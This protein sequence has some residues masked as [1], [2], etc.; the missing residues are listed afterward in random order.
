MTKFTR[1]DLGKQAVVGAAASVLSPFAG[2]QTS[3][4]Y[5]MQAALVSQWMPIYPGIWKATL[6]TPE[7]V[8]PVHSRLVQPAEAAMRK[9][10]LVESPP[11][12]A[13]TG[14]V[15][16]RGTTI[17]VPLAAHEELY[18]FG[19]QFFSLHHRG[20]K[21][22]IRVNADPRADTGDSHAPVP[23]YISSLGYGLFV[24]TA[25]YATFYCGNARPKPTEP[26][27]EQPSG[28]VPLY[29][30][31]LG[32]DQSSSVIADIPNA[33]GVDVYLFAGPTSLD[34]VRR[35]NLFSGGGTLPPEW[36]LGFWYRTESNATDAEVIATG[37]EFRDRNIPCDVIGL[38]AG[39]H[40]H[41]YSCTF[42]WN[43]ARFPNPQPFVRDLR[44][45]NYH[46][47]LWEHAF[48]HPSSP[49]FEPM[50]G[51]AGDKGVWGGL[52]PDF[53]NPQARKVFGN[54]HGEHLIDLGISG[55]KLDECD[56]SDYTGSWSFGEISQFPSGIDG[57]QMHCLFGL[58]YQK[59]LWDEYQ[60]R[61]LPTYN[62]VRSSGALAAPYPFVLYSDL[63]DHRQF[64]RALVN[65]SF[66][67][68][69]WCP[70]VRDAKSEEDLIRRLQSVM[71][72]PL[73]MING[74]Y[75]KNPPWKQLERRKN[76]AGNLTPNWEQLEERCREIIGWRMQ[77]LPYLQA[78][79]SRY[80]ADGTPPVRALA[81]DW[82]NESSV[83]STDDAWM[84]GDRM[85]VAPLFAGEPERKLTLPPGNWYDFW[86]GQK[87]TAGEI[88]VLPANTRNIPVYIKD[89]TV[90]PLAT[91]T[92]S[93]ADDNRRKLHV[94]VFGT[95][96]VPFEMQL[97]GGESLRCTWTASSKKGQVESHSL[98]PAFTAVEWTQRS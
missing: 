80:A 14:A 85:L 70:E 23:F 3:S 68:L 53:Q 32:E 84:L 9:L 67:G 36:G 56:N 21:R 62:L 75:I 97:P 43:R 89:G 88:L 47:N 96:E 10:P 27:G 55:F 79:F 35:Y 39:W 51:L 40:T 34:A 20:K 33:G 19:L 92:N 63:Y 90:L 17:S 77:I 66:S 61:R 45:K 41:A 2:S 13:P 16:A 4:S 74:W 8:T 73:A 15:T 95:G 54:Y 12:A 7:E 71:F 91:I 24:D 78:A 98:S 49:L 44:A 11:I 76:N 60:Q 5:K 42:A 37:Q 58:R 50:R 52:V 93:T 86:S 57:E 30:K 18:G 69:L 59:A 65:S 82:P 22:S 6:G 28:T 31:S 64:I 1:R 87:H 25:R 29:T 94:Q 72:S 81:L 26:Q 38:E 83:S 46:V 48:T